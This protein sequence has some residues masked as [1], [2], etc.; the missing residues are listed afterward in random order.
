[1]TERILRVLREDGHVLFETHISPFD[2]ITSDN[3]SLTVLIAPPA[4]KPKRPRKAAPLK[5]EPPKPELSS[6]AEPTV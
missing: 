2:Q 4:R 6:V 1:M 3:D 5:T